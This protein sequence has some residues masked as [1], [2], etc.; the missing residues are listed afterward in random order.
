VEAN[1]QQIQI[2][3]LDCYAIMHDVVRQLL[4][5]SNENFILTQTKDFKHGLFQLK[6]KHFDILMIGIS[7]VGAYRHEFPTQLKL[8]RHIRSRLPDLRIIV[9][10]MGAFRKDIADIMNAGADWF[11]SNTMGYETLIEAIRKVK[12]GQRHIGQQLWD[13]FKNS[14]EYLAG[15]ADTLKPKDMIFSQRELE[16][17]HLIASGYS[18]KQISDSLFITPKTVETHRK[19]LMKKSKTKNTAELISFSYDSGVL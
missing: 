4:A 3:Q 18:S 12:R 9:Y 13:L 5:N 15:L 14:I 16:V 2:L 10:S 19:N 1:T 7:N 6:K 8:L 17:L 11:I